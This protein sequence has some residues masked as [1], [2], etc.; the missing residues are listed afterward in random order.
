[1]TPAIP[2]FSSTVYYYVLR[3]Y[4][5]ILLLSHS[6]SPDRSPNRSRYV[7]ISTMAKANAMAI[8]VIRS[9][10]CGHARQRTSNALAQCRTHWHHG[11]HIEPPTF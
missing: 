11:A 4:V 7:Y 8:P 10:G 5:P 2:T 9:V 3:L 6:A 1:M